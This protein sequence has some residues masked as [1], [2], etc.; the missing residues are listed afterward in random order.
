MQDF[1][2]K[3]YFNTIQWYK[4]DWYSFAQ[5]ILFS[6]VTWVILSVMHNNPA[7]PES[8][9]TAHSVY[10]SV[11][12]AS[13]R[14]SPEEALPPETVQRMLKE[15]GL[16]DSHRNADGYGIFHKYELQ[17][18]GTVVCDHACSLM[19]QQAGSPNDMSYLDAKNYISALN[20][21]RLA[22][23]NNWRLPTLEEAI[24]LMEPVKKDGDLHIDPVFYPCQKRIWTSDFRK[25]GMAWTVSF[26]AG[27]C[28]YIYTDNNIKY[29]VRAVRGKT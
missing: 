20:K 24:S 9:G 25:A 22:G 2:H 12:R 6:T 21:D 23:Y 11:T 5:S 16:F 14:S 1:Q 7:F 19:W 26:D 29:Y 8:K 10:A 18:E 4:K 13:L 3:D 17:K 28:D 27:Y 15:K